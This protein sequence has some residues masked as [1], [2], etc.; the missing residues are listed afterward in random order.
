[1]KSNRFSLIHLRLKL[2]APSLVA[3][4]IVVPGTPLIVNH[5]PA[6]QE[7]NVRQIKII[8]SSD[9]PIAIK[10]IRNAQ[11][12]DFLQDLE[13]EIQNVSDKPVYYV[14]LHMRFPDIEFAPKQH[15]GFSLHY[16]DLKFDQVGELASPKD[17]PIPVGGTYIFKVP[18][19]ICKGFETY[20]TKKSLSQAATNKVEIGLMEVSFGDGTGYEYDR[21]YPRIKRAGKNLPAMLH[22]DNTH[23]KLIEPRYP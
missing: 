19:S 8:R 3:L 22:R 7:S 15:Y 23:R 9:H 17:Q 10:Q 2:L 1:M 21:P 12:S 14:H 6:S 16:S 13:I 20:K 18:I 5:P 4:A 11:S